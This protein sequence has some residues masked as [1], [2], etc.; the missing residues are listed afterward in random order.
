MNDE[1]VGSKT[2]VLGNGI[3]MKTVYYD[4]ADAVFQ[5]QAKDVSEHLKD[6]LNAFDDEATAKLLKMIWTDSE[7][8]FEIPEE[9]ELLRYIALSLLEDRSLNAVPL[10]YF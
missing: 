6:P 8:P 10:I 1:F 3:S 2:H 9:H 4:T 7:E 5:F